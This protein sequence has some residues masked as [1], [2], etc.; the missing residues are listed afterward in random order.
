MA[1]KKNQKRI[2]IILGILVVVLVI[3][4]VLKKR[5]SSDKQAVLT[6]QVELRD[7]LETVA[8]NGKVQPEKEVSMTAEIS[9]EIIDLPFKEGSL[10]KQGDLIVNINPDLYLAAQSRMEAS[11]NSAKAN[12]ANSKARVAQSRA[13]LINAKASFQRSKDLL[14]SKA[15]SQ[16]EYDQSLSQF[17]VAKADVEAAEQAL[18]SSEYSAKSTAASLKEANDNLKRTTIFSPLNGT[19]SKLDVEI[20][21]RVVGTSQMAGTEILRIADLTQME[22]NVE[23]NESD[24]VKV[25][26]GNSA[27]VE[28]DA[29]VDRFFDG[30]VTEI[31]NSSSST[32]MQGTDQ[33]TVFNVKVRILRSSYA[34][35]LD[36]DNPHLSPFRPGMSATVEIETN[37]R[38]NV[39]A[40]P[41]QA[42]TVRPDSTVKTS[43]KREGV[44]LEDVDDEHLEECVFLLESG[45][46]VKYKVQTGI[47]DDKYIEILSGIDTNATLIT[48]PYTLVSKEIQSG[49]EVE[50]GTREEVYEFDER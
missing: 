50:S 9:G 42:V 12:V 29:Y 18:R 46:A 48:G 5:F 47:Q 8:A 17:E 31:A 44:Q 16:A 37:K 41:I 11:L 4:G 35:L 49:D 6:E 32:S 34:D 30:V 28:V 14:E 23:V 43:S 25:K 26:L 1:M 39:V 20:G 19:I 2:V 40:V 13:Q 27:K 7:I 15:I 38:N 24:I 36:T 10:V 45:K 3:A 33:I 22:V 21:E